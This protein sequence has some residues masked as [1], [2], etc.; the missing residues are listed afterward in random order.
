M[1]GLCTARIAGR[2]LLTQDRRCPNP[3]TV[4]LTLGEI[5]DRAHRMLTTEGQTSLERHGYAGVCR[6]HRDQLRAA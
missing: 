4:L 2:G 6:D 5:T 3:S 1:T